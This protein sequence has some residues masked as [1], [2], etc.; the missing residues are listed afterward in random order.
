MNIFE[1]ACNLRPSE[2]RNVYKIY[3]NKTIIPV[4]IGVFRKFWMNYGK[5]DTFTSFK[6]LWF[7][8]SGNRTYTEE[9]W[10]WNI[11]RRNQ[12]GKTEK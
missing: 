9:D 11:S 2:T 1:I 6:F 5:F 4:A 8:S 12:K 3:D 10:M 7:F